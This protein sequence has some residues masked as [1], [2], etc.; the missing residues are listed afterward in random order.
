MTATMTP[1]DTTSP[2]ARRRPATARRTGPLSGAMDVPGDKSISHR[3]LMLGALAV[4]TVL[5]NRS[6]VVSNSGDR[7]LV[8]QDAGGLQ[9]FKVGHGRDA[10]AQFCLAQAVGPIEWHHLDQST[11]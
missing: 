6:R 3:A 10:K 1:P 5:A 4:G 7:V 8:Q 11:A 2:E 9:V